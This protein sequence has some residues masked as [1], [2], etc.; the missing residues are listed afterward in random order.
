MW[1]KKQ[2]WYYNDMKTH[3]SMFIDFIKRHKVMTIITGILLVAVATWSISNVIPHPLGDKMEYLGKEDYGCWVGFCDSQPAS[4]YY[5]GTDMDTRGVT[6]YFKKSTVI[7]EPRLSQGKNYFGIQTP[8]GETI[9][10]PLPQRQ[11]QTV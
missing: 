6:E 10:I 5:Y 4:I 8:S 9:Y 2:L 11:T 1:L 7:E 3:A